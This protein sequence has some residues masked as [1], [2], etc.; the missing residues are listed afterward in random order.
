MLF[1]K[2]VV[3]NS[4]TSF[5]LILFKYAGILHTEFYTTD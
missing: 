5:F 1:E 3:D 2:P 4:R